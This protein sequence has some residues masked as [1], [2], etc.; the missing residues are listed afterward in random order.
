MVSP[1]LTPLLGRATVSTDITVLFGL[2]LAAVALPADELPSCVL[3]LAVSAMLPVELP[4]PMLLEVPEEPDVPELPKEPEVPEL[5]L[6]P[7]WS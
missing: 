6:E 4:S 7:D 1:P 3:P 5:P 2:E